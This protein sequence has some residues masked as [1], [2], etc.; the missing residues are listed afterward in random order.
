MTEAAQSLEDLVRTARDGNRESLERLVLSIQDQIHGLALRMLWNREDAKDAAQEILVR[1]VTRLG[2]FR[3]AS[4]FTTWVYRVAANYLLTARKSRLEE[5]RYTFQRFGDE[6][7]T[8][9]SDEGVPHGA[10]TALLLEE[11]KIG[12]T[13]GMLQCLD[14]PHRLAYILGEILEMEGDEAALALG[15]RPAAFRKRLSRARDAVVAFTQ[16]KCGLVNPARSCRCRRRLPAALRLGRVAPGR[17]LFATDAGRAR[18][19]PHVL[20]EIRR[21]EEVRRAAALLR[22]HPP[23]PMPEDAVA[24]IRR[25]VGDELIEAWGRPRGGG[26]RIG[27]HPRVVQA[28]RR[29][30]RG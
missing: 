27:S 22:S 26:D 16:A 8:G 1:I 20:A 24:D 28:G 12:C 29:G 2:T 3:G 7:D 25:L 21:L 5:Q 30:V 17:P 6:L 14:R 10:D 23:F 9:L 15:I 18:S 11:V 19:F 4:R 13:L